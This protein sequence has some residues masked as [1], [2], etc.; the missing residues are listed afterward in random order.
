MT[1]EKSRPIIRWITLATLLLTWLPTVVLAQP[2]LGVL[3]AARND[4]AEQVRRALYNFGPDADSRKA[5]QK[6]LDKRIEA[7]RSIGDLHEAFMLREWP[8]VPSPDPNLPDP[9]GRDK[10]ANRLEKALREA[11]E[12][13]SAAR[14][15]AAATFFGEMGSTP[16]D[17]R[18]AEGDKLQKALLGRLLPDVA[19]LSSNT[20]AGVREAAARAL[21]RY[22][23]GP[24]KAIEE[25]GKFLKDRDVAVRRAAAEGLVRQVR[26]GDPTGDPIPG[27]PSVPRTV[28]VSKESAR[29]SC[30][31]RPGGSTTKTS[32]SV[33]IVRTP[34]RK[35]PGP[36]GYSSVRLSRS[37][38]ARCLSRSR[39]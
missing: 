31:W 21:G 32:R 29:P 36:S 3:P 14:Q 5:A 7:L 17:W 8:D 19:G 22:I 39:G 20:D 12:K 11:L 15:C 26:G 9:V 30:R 38:C 24:A 13:G 4:A 16:P 6:E 18:G 10:I 28:P 35:R 33:A 25:L 2:V 1:A 23:L 37:A 34:S 27:E